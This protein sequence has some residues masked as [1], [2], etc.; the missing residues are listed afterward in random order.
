M[1]KIPNVCDLQH[2]LV[3]RG[4]GSLGEAIISSCCC[5]EIKKA[6]PKVR[7]TVACFGPA[8]DFFKP[9]PYVDEVFKLPVRTHI[10]PHQRWLRL[11]WAAL[12]LRRKHFDLVLDSGRKDSLNWRMFKYVV[13][14]GKVLDC[15]TSPV[16]PFG[17]P[18]QHGSEHEAAIL[19]LLGIAQPDKSYDLPLLPSARKAVADWLESHRVEKYI[20][21]NP[22]GSLPQCRFRPDTVKEICK[23]L[24]DLQMP[25]VIV[26]LFCN[27]QEMTNTFDKQP[28]IFIKQPEDIFELFEWV[29]RACLVVTPDTSVVHIASGFEKPSLAFYTSPEAYSLPANPK[30]YVLE[31]DSQDVNVFDWWKLESLIDRI[32]KTI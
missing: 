6:N 12:K 20:L 24:E 10:R 13:G 8:Y 32:K 2:I 3:C 16:Q 4:E 18:D 25:V 15:F 19:E 27:V 11:L 17:A 30:A 31:T 29:H 28:N 14:G 23:V 26:T 5:R 7:I 9:N 22:A 1:K 21:F